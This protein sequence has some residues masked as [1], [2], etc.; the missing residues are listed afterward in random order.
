ME[1]LDNLPNGLLQGILGI[2]AGILSTLLAA[3]IRKKN[4]KRKKSKTTL[5]STLFQKHNEKSEKY[6]Q[7]DPNENVNTPF[8]SIAFPIISNVTNTN[9]SNLKKHR[10]SIEFCL[11][12]FLFPFFYDKKRL[13]N[14]AYNWAI[15]EA[16][17]LSITNKN[18]LLI[19]NYKLYAS[20][21]ITSLLNLLRKCRQKDRMAVVF[22]AT[23]QSPGELSMGIS[24]PDTEATDTFSKVNEAYRDESRKIIQQYIGEQRDLLFE[25]HMFIR[26][27]EDEEF[28]SDLTML[29]N[30]FTRIDSKEEI[31]KSPKEFI[32]WINNNHA[33]SVPILKQEMAKKMAR[34]QWVKSQS[35]QKESFITDSICTDLI[36]YGFIERGNIPRHYFDDIPPKF[37]KLQI[38][39][40]FGIQSIDLGRIAE[41]RAIKLLTHNPLNSDKIDFLGFNYTSLNSFIQILQEGNIGNIKNPIGLTK[42]KF[43]IE[44]EPWKKII[45]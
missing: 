28:V 38:E 26:D 21:T 30:V 2:I 16:F 33:M 32:N 35:I 41:G 31:Q 39:W 11:D 13:K 22:I 29:E 10:N 23:T 42:S 7:P 15:L 4:E 8:A 3:H 6:Y 43:L 9:D 1:F 19:A 37:S 17:F 40:Q 5:T 24:S 12:D 27:I 36:V 44:E 20:A 34:I 18:N 25:R 14:D 45:R